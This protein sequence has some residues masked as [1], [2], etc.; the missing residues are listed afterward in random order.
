MIVQKNQF[1]KKNYD[2]TYEIYVQ[3]SDKRNH[4]FNV[5]NNFTIEKLKYLISKKVGCCVDSMRLI[6]GGKQLEDHKKLSNYSFVSGSILYL[7]IRL[8]G[9]MFVPE[10]SGNNDYRKIKKYGN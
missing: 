9:G 4:C 6:F 8:R 1:K 5:T 3:D 7:V 2:D 10:T